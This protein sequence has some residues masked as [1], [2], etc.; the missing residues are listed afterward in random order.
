MVI[1]NSTNVDGRIAA[2]IGSDYLPVGSGARGKQRT[3]LESNA[4][5][6]KGYEAKRRCLLAL[7]E[8][9]SAVDNALSCI[10]DNPD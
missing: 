3:Q 2:F 6:V 7:A 8:F 9:I 5:R 1:L 10:K 4:N